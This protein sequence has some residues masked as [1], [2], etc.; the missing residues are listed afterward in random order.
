MEVSSTS[1]SS[2]CLGGDLVILVVGATASCARFDVEED[3][4]AKDC[5][6]EVLVVGRSAGNRTWR[7]RKVWNCVDV[8][9][10]LGAGTLRRVIKAPSCLAEY[11][12]PRPQLLQAC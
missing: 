7:V 6:E 11:K 9:C 12:A 3:S 4:R 2:S 5:R 10:D 8:G 1:T